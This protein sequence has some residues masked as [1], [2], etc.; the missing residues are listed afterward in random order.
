MKLLYIVRKKESLITLSICQC[1]PET[2]VTK[3]VKT[4]AY[5]MAFFSNEMHLYVK[6]FEFIL[7]LLHVTVDS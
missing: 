5:N 2:K 3:M 6:Q 1:L 7:V 4:R